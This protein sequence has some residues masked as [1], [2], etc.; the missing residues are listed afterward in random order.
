[1]KESNKIMKIKKNRKLFQT[2]SHTSSLTALVKRSWH[3][4]TNKQIN[5]AKKTDLLPTTLKRI[6]SRLMVKYGKKKENL[7]VDKNKSK[8]TSKM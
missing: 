6:Q 5:M 1:M 2:P 3:T 8:I 7:T 4:N